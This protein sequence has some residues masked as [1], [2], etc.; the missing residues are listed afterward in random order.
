[1]IAGFILLVL[2][3][4]QVAMLAAW[5][6]PNAVVRI[7]LASGQALAGALMGASVILQRRRARRASNSETE[8]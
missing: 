7:V 3:F 1:M 6:R 2:G 4:A 8:L 5:E